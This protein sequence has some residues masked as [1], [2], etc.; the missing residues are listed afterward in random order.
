MEKESEVRAGLEHSGDWV[1]PPRRNLLSDGSW[2]LGGRV[3]TIFAT[4]ASNALLARLL[5][6]EDLGTYFLAFSIVSFGA[7]VGSLGLNQVVV[8]FVAE[9]MSLNRPERARRTVYLV[10]VLGLAGA[11]GVGGGYLLLGDALGTSLF[12]SPA[13][14]AVTG[15]IAGWMVAMTLQMLLSETFRGFHDIRLATLF[16]NLV[17][18][19]LLTVSLG[20]LWLLRGE[21]TLATAVLLAMG[22]GFSSVSLGGLL[23]R[24]RLAAL[25]QE[26]KSQ[27]GFGAILPVAWPLLIANLTV[28]VVTQADLWVLGAFRP[29]EEVGIYGAAA[30]MVALVMIPLAIVNAVASP[31]IAQMYARG[32]RAELGGIL[33][34]MATLAGIPALLAL[35]GIVFLGGPLLGLVYGDYYREGAMVLALLSPGQLAIVWSGS[36][37]LALAMTGHHKVLMAISVL[38]GVFIIGAALGTVGPY[39]TTGVALATST[40]LGLQ[41]ALMV[42]AVKRRTGMWT[43]AGLR[44]SN[45]A[46]AL[47][48]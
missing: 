44:F 13:L 19:L 36:C 28:F 38:T 11:L 14:S 32:S 8:R 33:R 9:S 42:L 17:T 1:A 34:S 18:A 22:S 41:H 45:L 31:L 15:L 39:G 46:K 29:P 5:A 20:L 21:T 12:G 16:N 23:L 43:H 6:P 10:C 3:T 2:A 7:L 27:M 40:G 37:G 30:R 47:G 24:R 35:V 25:P 48:R 26:A 4:V